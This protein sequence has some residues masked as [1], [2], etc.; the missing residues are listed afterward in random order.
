MYRLKTADCDVSD[1]ELSVYYGGNGDIYVTI[2]DETGIHGVRLCTSGGPE[3]EQPIRLAMSRVA[4]EFV[5][6]DE[7]G[8]ST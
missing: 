1:A 6:L 3:K 7:D 8:K 5:K 4:N 2:Y